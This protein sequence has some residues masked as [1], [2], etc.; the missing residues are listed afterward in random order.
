MW[1][2]TGN[3]VLPLGQEYLHLLILQRWFSEH[4]KLRQDT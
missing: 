3:S 1:R 2:G 4:G